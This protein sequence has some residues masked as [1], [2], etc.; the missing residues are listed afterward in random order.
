TI[1]KM[2]QYNLNAPRPI[3]ITDSY[4]CEGQKTLALITLE[5]LSRAEADI[6]ESVRLA[7]YTIFETAS[8]F[9]GVGG[10]INVIKLD[11]N[12]LVSMLNENEVSNALEEGKNRY[13]RTNQT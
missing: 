12:G 10:P 4:Y 2:Y 1:K 9:L 13:E 3:P 8:N 6:E 5:S 11:D 7:V